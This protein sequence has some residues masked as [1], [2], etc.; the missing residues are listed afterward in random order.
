MH[1]YRSVK[2]GLQAVATVDLN[3][4]G[5]LDILAA[6]ARNGHVTPL[7]GNG[8]N[9]FTRQP[10]LLAGLGTVALATGDLNDDQLPDVVTANKFV[11]TVS[12]LINVGNGEVLRSDLTTGQQ[13][14]DVAIGDLNRDGRAD[15]VVANQADSTLTLFVQQPDESYLRTDVPTGSA[16]EHL[17][18]KD[19]NG[20]GW[21]DIAVTVPLSRNVLVHLG[22]ADGT[23]SE[24]LTLPGDFALCNI[25]SGD[26]NADGRP[27]LVV[28]YPDEQRVGILYGQGAGRFTRPQTI[29]VG[30]SPSA[31]TLADCD[32][33]GR[34]DIVVSSTESDRATVLFNRYDPARAYAYQA[35]A[36]DPDG[37]PLVF[38][39]QEGP[40]G[41]MLDASSGMIGWSPNSD[42]FGEHRVTL[43]VADGR[44][45]V[46]TQTWSIAV[47][48]PRDN[49]SPIV[50]S[51]PVTLVPG[52]LPY[53]YPVRA[54][55]PDGDPLHV[56]LTGGPA[57]MSFDPIGQQLEWDPRGTALVFAGLH[58]VDIPDTDSLHPRNLTLET[59]IRFDEETTSRRELF[60]KLVG[61]RES[62]EVYYYNNALYARAG[63]KSA[64]SGVA[65]PFIPEVG[66]WYHVAYTYDDDNDIH[67]IYVDAN[68]V[69]SVATT[70]SL[71]YDTNWIRI[72]GRADDAY[73]RGAIDEIRIWS[74]AR[75]E[76]Q[77]R[78]D[79]RRA[80]QGDEPGLIGYY[81]ADEGRGTILYDHSGHL[82]HG[83]L[84]EPR[85]FPPRW[86]TSFGVGRT[87]RVTIRARDVWGAVT[88][89]TFTLT[90][91]ADRTASIQGFV[92]DD[93][94]ADGVYQ[95]DTETGL[96]GAV[97]FLD[98]NGNG[99]HD[100]AERTGTTD[101]SG[102][103]LF[104]DL[105]V[106]EYQL[107]LQGQRRSRAAR[108]RLEFPF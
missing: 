24:V 100:L 73:L 55:D 92:F 82:N 76:E 87:E 95:A 2:P 42:Q 49:H 101:A 51:D 27:D 81:P 34:L 84:G 59:W 32:G 104:T 102:A 46:A 65:I 43:A 25:A 54:A 7:L 97:V 98:G 93:Q 41:M 85:S 39:L 50:L 68:Q 103:Y 9:T 64:T 19:L 21:L 70:L 31:L 96:A 20:D 15:L 63:S 22:A 52:T 71:E 30:Q 48:I 83:L 16:P 36:E 11:N 45:G 26:I 8:D 67:A 23:F 108:Y 66:R 53:V 56:Q 37:D 88:E 106:G 91:S 57:G 94:N 107:V 74:V 28:S 33:D 13:P 18:L 1:V 86:E 10:D 6:N 58:R 44:G 5:R 77:I 12:L 38:T 99:L 4:D 89:Q 80:L 17:A 72:G 60:Q 79:M 3:A 14:T 62:F 90:V 35:V 105:V 47:G 69:G 78:G 40:G 75:D 61:S 29:D